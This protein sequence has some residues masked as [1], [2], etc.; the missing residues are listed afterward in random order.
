[1]ITIHQSHSDKLDELEK[2]IQELERLVK[3]I[4]ILGKTM[5]I[6]HTQFTAKVEEVKITSKHHKQYVIR[7][8]NGFAPDST[9]WLCE[10][11]VDLKIG[12]TVIITVE[13]ES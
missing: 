5:D 8:N 12:S 11:D 13:S 1:M 10:P 9:L 3:Y 6:M 4:L 7:K 2:R